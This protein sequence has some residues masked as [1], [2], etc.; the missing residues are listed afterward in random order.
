MSDRRSIGI[1]GGTFDPIHFGHL[2]CADAAHRALGLDRVL[3]MP[4]HDPP[5]RPNDPHVSAYHRFALVALAIADRSAY[6]A[7]DR[8]L[9]QPGP[10]YSSLTLQRLHADGF[11]AG[12]LCFILGSD[13]F[14]EIPTWYD[15]PAILDRAHFAVVARPGLTLAGV[16]ARVPELRD[17]FEYVTGGIARPG[18]RPRVWLIE[19]T[20]RDV[21][22][23]AIRARL[24]EGRSIADLAPAAV[25]A[26]I[27]R[28]ELYDYR[29]RGHEQD[30][31]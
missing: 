3:V 26:Y 27:R 20:T 15:Y 11:A 29:G 9:Q 1:L 4:A 19:A 31:A 16:Q 28:H 24:A 17:R 30:Q 21:S 25:D 6:V 12:R 13:T 2:D 14:A 18:E 8:E 5:H 10:S 22:S 7:S 23:T